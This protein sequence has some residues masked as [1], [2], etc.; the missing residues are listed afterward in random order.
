MILVTGATG[1]VGTQVIRTLRKLSLDTRAL[2]RKGSEYY[3]LNDTGCRFFFGDLRDESSVR[4][5]CRDA[6]YLIVCSGV[7]LETRDNHHGNVT[8]EGHARLFQA[9]RDRGVQHIVLISCMGVDRGYGIRG[10]DA[11]KDAED[12]LVQSGVDYTILRAC[13]HEHFFLDMAW[14]IHDS[15]SVTLPGDG[16]NQLSPIATNDLALMA[17]ASLDLAAVKNRVV[18]VGGGANMN[19][20]E[21]LRQACSAVGVE[22]N[23]QSMPQALARLGGKVGRPFRRYARRLAERGIWFS[24]EFTVASDDMTKT[25]N[26]PL[27]ALADALA[28]GAEE[29]RTLRDPEMRERKM[30]HP[31]FYATVY[32]PGEANLADLPSGPPPR[33]D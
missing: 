8:V 9:A 19:A 30:V 25:F 12:L 4:R 2:V 6:Q 5:A 16:D 27:T 31:Q 13:A 10:F 33:Q 7:D 11:R 21:A 26:I 22:P 18:T 3:W 20:G 15:G 32:Q 29:T 14:Q 23:H 17:V 28:A 1:R 24:E